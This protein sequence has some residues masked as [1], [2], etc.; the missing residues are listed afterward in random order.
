MPCSVPQDILASEYH[1]NQ[2]PPEHH[3]HLCGRHDAYDIQ[4]WLKDLSAVN[5]NTIII[6]NL[7]FKVFF[8]QSII[9]PQDPLPVLIGLSDN[10]V[11]E[12]FEIGSLLVCWCN[13]AEL[14]IHSSQ[15]DIWSLYISIC[16]QDLSHL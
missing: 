1:Q 4:H 8:I 6:T 7:F 11:V 10:T 2:P 14:I 16:C 5:Y 13:D 12:F 15:N 3:P 9:Q